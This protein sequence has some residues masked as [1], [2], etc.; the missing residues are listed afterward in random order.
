MIETFRT[1]LVL[2]TIR[3]ETIYGS[4]GEPLTREEIEKAA[5]F[6]H[7]MHKFTHFQ[8]GTDKG[9]VILKG[10]EVSY[11]LIQTEEDDDGSSN[12]G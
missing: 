9:I 7:D 12:E 10:S 1:R 6:F 3:G 8:L 2:K 4:Y 5:E 11:V